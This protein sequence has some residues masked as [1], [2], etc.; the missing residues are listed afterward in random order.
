M[1]KK[2]VAKKQ[3]G[4]K[5]VAT[6]QEADKRGTK[7]GT[8]PSAPRNHATAEKAVS[9]PKAFGFLLCGSEDFTGEQVP[10]LSPWNHA[11]VATDIDH[12]PAIIVLL[13]ERRVA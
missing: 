9:T 11:V 5:R 13:P 12:L 2:Q 3:V 1:S 10:V 7:R 8:E 4:K 6:K